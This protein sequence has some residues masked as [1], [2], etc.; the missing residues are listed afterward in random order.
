MC[1]AFSSVRFTRRILETRLEP[2][3][4]AD[5]ISRMRKWPTTIMVTMIAIKLNAVFA[6]ALSSPADIRLAP[7]AAHPRA[8]AASARSSQRSREA[9]MDRL[10]NSV[11]N[12]QSAITPEE[13]KLKIMINTIT[14]SHDAPSATPANM[15]TK[16]IKPTGNVSRN[17]RDA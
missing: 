17:N 5:F 2:N 10:E 9:P 6:N 13:A 11:V 14:V 8:A 3:R 4:F 7:H 12:T 15:P 16:H 1:Q